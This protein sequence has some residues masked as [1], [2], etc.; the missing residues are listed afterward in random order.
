MSEYSAPLNFI[1]LGSQQLRIKDEVN[2]AYCKSINS[3]TIYY[4][5]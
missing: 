5:T 3:W 1:D 4:G 2:S